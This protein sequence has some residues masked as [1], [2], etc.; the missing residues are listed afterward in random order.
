MQQLPHAPQALKRVKQE[1]IYPNNC[2]VRGT[3]GGRKAKNSLFPPCTEQKHF[4]HPFKTCNLPHLC[5]SFYN[6]TENTFTLSTLFEKPLL[7]IIETYNSNRFF[8]RLNGLRKSPVQ[9]S[10]KYSP[11]Q[12][13]FIPTQSLKLGVSFL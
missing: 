13:M 10:A 12:L 9:L 6:H 8:P 7:P 1:I 3:A 5:Q 2:D 11:L 4:Q